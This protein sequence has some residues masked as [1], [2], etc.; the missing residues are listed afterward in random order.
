VFDREFFRET[1][2]DRVREFAMEQ[3]ATSVKLVAVTRDGTSFD[4]QEFNTND[5]GIRLVTVNRVM[6]FLSYDELARLEVS[7]PAGVE[8]QVGFRVPDE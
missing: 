2:P 4:T 6:V 3:E 1:F 5:A 7:I 8:G